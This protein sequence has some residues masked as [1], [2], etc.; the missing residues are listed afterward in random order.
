MPTRLC[1]GR[2]HNAAPTAHEAEGMSTIDIR[3]THSM[4][5][6]QVREAVQRMAETLSERFGLAWAWQGD[7]LLFERSGVD[8]RIDVAPDVLHVT[9]KLGFLLGAMKG[10]IEHEIRRVLAER[11]N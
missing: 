10:P 2:A 9:A 6:A 3:H 1:P 7:S 11:F 8:G 4:S 5:H